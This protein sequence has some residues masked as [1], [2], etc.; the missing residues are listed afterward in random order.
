MLVLI[1]GENAMFREDLV[2]K[3]EA[4]GQEAGVSL[5]IATQ[6]YIARLLPDIPEDYRI[7]T[8]VFADL[9]KFSRY[10]QC[11][12]LVNTAQTLQDFVRGFTKSHA[13][14]DFV[15][16]S[17]SDNVDGVAAKMTGQQR[18]Y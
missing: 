5:R 12:G 16:V 10:C 4:G 6:D 1:D 2:M 14:F 18:T 17:A 8:R 15:D 13:L 9:R 7:V 11:A 3:G